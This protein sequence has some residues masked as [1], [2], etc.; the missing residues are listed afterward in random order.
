M[1]EPERVHNG[2]IE[3]Y[4]AS[5]R[6]ALVMLTEFGPADVALAQGLD[7]AVLADVLCGVHAV[8]TPPNTVVFVRRHKSAKRVRT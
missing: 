4:V 2:S 7:E 8:L 6:D 5:E 3:R 1:G